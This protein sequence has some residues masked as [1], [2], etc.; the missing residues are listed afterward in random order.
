MSPAEAAMRLLARRPGLSC[1]PRV[2][3][4]VG[5]P[6]QSVGFRGKGSKY[7]NACGGPL[8]VHAMR[9]MPPALPAAGAARSAAGLG[10]VPLLHADVRVRSAERAACALTALLSLEAAAFILHDPLSALEARD[11]EGVAADVIGALSAFGVQ[12]LEG[13]YGAL[14]RLLQWVQSHQP[15]ASAVTGS[16]VCAFLSAVQPSSS[17]L[18][19]LQ[20]LRDHCGLDLPSG[21][22]A[23]LRRFRHPPPRGRHVKESFT[24][25]I[26]LGLEAIA[27]SHASGFVRGHAAGWAFL[28]L[29]ALRVEQSMDLSINAFVPFECQGWKGRITVAATARDKHPDARA[30]R[31]RPVWGTMEGLLEG[32]A[33][34]SALCA[35]L[36][37]AEEARC[38]IR[39]TNARTGDPGEATAWVCSGI[40]SQS[41][42]AASL[43]ALLQLPPIS[44]A[45]ERAAR[46]GGHAAK[47]FLLNVAQ[48]SPIVSP[49]EANDLGRFSRSSAQ[50]NDV[51][52]VQAMLEAHRLRASALPDIYAQRAI[53][54]GA[55]GLIAKVHVVLREAALASRE[56]PELLEDDVCWGPEGPFAAAREGMAIGCAMPLARDDPRLLLC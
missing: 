27:A 33:M 46:F 29:H 23:A 11:K 36:S 52:P 32:D 49:M 6:L 19:S 50:S 5:P 24:L 14:G 43:H 45:R 9:R 10:D 41:R 15:G 22:G 53:V 40:E 16:M 2:A 3:C 17:L 13:A 37:G 44:M 51:V 1:A 31:P 42:R 55:F 56:H 18:S 47:R 38:V 39:D 12:S 4:L 25:R 28:A 30:A 21:R 34:L 8:A 7:A 35:M 26:L 20:W 48:A 54:Q